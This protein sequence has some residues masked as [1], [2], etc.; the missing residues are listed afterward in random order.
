[1]IATH[2]FETARDLT[3]CPPTISHYVSESPPFFLAR[4]V[5]LLEG[6]GGDFSESPCR[7]ADSS[8]PAYCSIAAAGPSAHSRVTDRSS[9][10]LT[11][12]Q[13]VHYYAYAD[14]GQVSWYLAIVPLWSPA[15]EAQ[16]LLHSVPDTRRNFCFSSWH[17][18][19]KYST[20]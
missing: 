2:P 18:L 19:H 17:A 20:R 4:P 6:G 7:R 15:A 10:A 3:D 14:Q 11:A 1:M 9:L 16:C 13:V 8:L 5:A 12:T